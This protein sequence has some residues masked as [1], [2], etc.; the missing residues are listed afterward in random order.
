MK[1]KWLMSGAALIIGIPLILS[2]C[3]QW[4]A[5][6]Q[7]DN[8]KNVN[9]IDQ[10]DSLNKK[11]NENKKNEETSAKMGDQ[12]AETASRTL[13]LVD[14]NGLVVP[15]TFQLPIPKG[16]G[17]A[18]QALQ[19]LVKGGPVS[20]LLPNGFQAVLPAGTDVIAA[21]LNN[22]TLTVNFSKPF[23]SYKKSQEKNILQ[24][25]TW[26]ATQFDNIDH[27]K[28]QVDGVAQKAMPVKGTP[29]GPK[30]A[31][32]SDGINEEIGQVVDVTGTRPVTLYFP[33]QVGNE[34]YYVPVT[35]RMNV[36]KGKVVAA[37]NGLLN[38][39]SS[40]DGLL[41]VFG[42]NVQLLGDPQFH[43]G[44]VTLNFNKAI[45]S[46]PKKK[47]ISTEQLDA[48]VLSLTS[49]PRIHKVA[50]QVNGKA[51]VKT[52]AGKVLSKPVSRGQVVKTVG[53]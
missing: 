14:K 49:Q 33:A 12:N 29:I 36:G 37:V 23:A 5:S 38:G 47:T 26:T 31:S 3:G 17:V 6:Q 45:Y 20:N 42:K 32:R 46:D 25:V 51:S 28:I 27:V 48:L 15:Q 11:Q 30:G 18:Q 40:N 43:N 44:V 22:G 53:L 9:Y 2:G 10:G 50:I 41:D 35:T 19:Y 39:P 21:N 24:A 1:R 52:E 4:G 8:P 16:G 34:Y 7:A 13:Y